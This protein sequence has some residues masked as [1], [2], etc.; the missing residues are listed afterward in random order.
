M[1]AVNINSLNNST[2]ISRG[3]RLTT[4]EAADFITT[5]GI[6]EHISVGDKFTVTKFDFLNYLIIAQRHDGKVLSLPYDIVLHKTAISPTELTQVVNSVFVIERTH[7]V[8]TKQVI[9]YGTI[10]L[11]AFLVGLLF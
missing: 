8:I 6:R 5:D 4:I 3:S 10:V 2:L 1:N 11:L 9:I 7:E